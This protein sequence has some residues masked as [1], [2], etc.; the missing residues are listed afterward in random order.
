[1]NLLKKWKF[2]LL[3]LVLLASC[4]SA[5]CGCP[6]AETPKITKDIPQSPKIYHKVIDAD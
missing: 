4:K 6:M 5:D 3:G 1:M 2:Y